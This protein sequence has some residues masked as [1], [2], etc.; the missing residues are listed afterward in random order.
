MLKGRNIILQ[1]DLERKAELHDVHCALLT[2]YYNV[3]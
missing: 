2:G 1:E 3:V